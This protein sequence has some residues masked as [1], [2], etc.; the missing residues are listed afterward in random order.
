MVPL[1]PGWTQKAALISL[2]LCLPV[3]ASDFSGKVV[4]ITDGDTITI[5]M[6]DSQTYRV[7]L[8]EI[9]APERGQPFGSRSTQILKSLIAGKHIAVRSQ[10]RDRYGRVIGRLY[11]E[12]TDINR[13]MVRKGAA[14]V[15]RKYMTDQS[16]LKDEL[17]AASTQQGLWALPSA[18]RIPPWEWRQNKRTPAAQ[19]SP[20]ANCGSKYTCSVMSS[21]KEALFHLRTCGLTRL[22]GDGDGIP[23]ETLCK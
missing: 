8:A 21:C 5:L 1:L 10:G 11:F 13:E 19:S 16:L 15:Y 18:E 2:L 14:W 4:G 12:N 23:C 3:S 20:P 7:R 6:P 17:R 22:D 9:D